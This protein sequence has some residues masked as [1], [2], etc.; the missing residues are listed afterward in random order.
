MN[1]T[2]VTEE[3]KSEIIK[4]DE[5]NKFTANKTENDLIS[6]KKE[7]DISVDH[8]QMDVVN[9][10]VTMDIDD[11]ID[12]VMDTNDLFCILNSKSS[13][14]KPD[15]VDDDGRKT[16]SDNTDLKDGEDLDKMEKI[17]VVADEKKTK[18]ASRRRRNSL[19]YLQ[20]WSWHAKRKSNR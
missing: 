4:T 13:S 9:E 8:F 18:S 5:S 3:S 10:I 12:N 1:E 15:F 6:D 2:K 11:K 17:E 16:E 14:S 19:S 20:P 7:R